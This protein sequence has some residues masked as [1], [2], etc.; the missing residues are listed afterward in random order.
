MIYMA[1][2]ELEKSAYY[3]FNMLNSNEKKIYNALFQALMKVAPSVSLPFSVKKETVEKTLQFVIYDRPDIFWFTGSYTMTSSNNLVKSVS[4]DYRMS[5]SEVDVLKNRLLNSVF[6]KRMDALILS[7]KTVF[8]KALVAYE[9]IIKNADYD[10]VAAEYSSVRKY[11]YAYNID[12]IIMNS[13]AVC[14]G[15]SKTFQYFMNRHRIY[16]T[17]V[18]GSTKRGR[19]AWN[20]INIAGSYYYIDTT[21]GDPVFA[22]NSNKSSDYISYDFFCITTNDLKKSH[23][24]NID[25]KM[26]LCTDTR[27][28]YYRYFNLISDTFSVYDVVSRLISAYRN[29]KNEAEIKYS[30]NSE[31]FIAKRE[32]F[33][34]EKIFDVLS[35][36]KQTVT[37]INDRQVNYSTN[38]DRN[39]IKI[40]LY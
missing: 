6:F 8:E 25:Y 2:F 38:D 13:K 3:Y 15:Y 31:Y 11:D 17:F 5:K 29:G 35:K 33:D 10:R 22:N 28:N 9:Y 36:A 30:S 16:C 12:G 20:L 24:A 4:F 37:K 32:L 39:T 18:A 14:A 1:G 40:K 7:K 23:A 27:C 34:N 19:H 21:W 26:P